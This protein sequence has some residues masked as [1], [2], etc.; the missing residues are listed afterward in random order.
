MP[1]KYAQL[2][3][4]DWLKTKYLEERLSA[5]KIAKIIGCSHA[6]VLVALRRFSI[7]IRSL[8]EERK[9]RSK[10]KELKDGDWLY[11][12]YLIEGWDTL[13]IAD[14]VGCS[15]NTVS[16]ALKHFDIPMRTLSAAMIRYKQLWNK[17]WLEKK[18][19]H[20]HNY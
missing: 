17:E 18:Y 6:P 11:Q 16:R 9:G 15:W 20:W 1:S 14:F 19:L 7:K 12:K 4:R 2:N 3:D 5:R 8:S 10:Y 13:K